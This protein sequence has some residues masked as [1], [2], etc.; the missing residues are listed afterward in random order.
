MY[1]P[2][3][4]A[5]AEELAGRRAAVEALE[6]EALRAAT[7]PAEAGKPGALAPSPSPP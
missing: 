6:L 3:L 1:C 7:P 5:A 2:Q 4:E